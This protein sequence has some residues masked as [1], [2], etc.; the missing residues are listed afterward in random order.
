MATPVGHK[1]GTPT[2]DGVGGMVLRCTTLGCAMDVS[3]EGVP[4]TEYRDAAA[5]LLAA[6][7]EVNR[8]FG[9]P[10]KVPVPH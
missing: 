10:Y 9:C 5:L 8:M 1:W 7:K 4:A 2:A 3:V 6:G